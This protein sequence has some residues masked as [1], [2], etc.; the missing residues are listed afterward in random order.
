M[1]RSS[2]QPQRMSVVEEGRMYAASRVRKSASFWMYLRG[3]DAS[4]R[5]TPRREC[6]NAARAPKGV[7]NR[8]Q[9]SATLA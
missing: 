9:M 8:L 7:Y 5:G 6:V 4:R 3:R 2:R 1:L